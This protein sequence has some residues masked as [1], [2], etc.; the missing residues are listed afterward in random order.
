MSTA[1]KSNFVTDAMH[2][3]AWI[4]DTIERV[5]CRQAAYPRVAAQQDF[6][7]HRFIQTLRGLDVSERHI[8]LITS[9]ALS[10]STEAMQAVRSF[11]QSCAHWCLILLGEP[12]VGKTVAADWSLAHHARLADCVS[13]P[14]ACKLTGWDLGQAAFKSHTL[15]RYA[16]SEFLVL[17]DLWTEVLDG[18]GRVSAFLF[19]LINRRWASQSRTI[20]TSN[21]TPTQL[22]ARYGGRIF[23]RLAHQS[24][25]LI[26]R[27][28]SLRHTRPP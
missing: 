1:R 26:L 20:I 17:D 2:T 23:D 8:P 13:T 7:Q 24:I 4:K 15:P 14:M 5:R 27:G 22:R 9:E 12:G 25:C 10:D 28:R 16:R 6:D 18:H 19:E 11:V 3:H 21:L